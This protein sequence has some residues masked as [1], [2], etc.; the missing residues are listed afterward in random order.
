MPTTGWHI[1]KEED[2]LDH[3]HFSARAQVHLKLNEINPS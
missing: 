2:S 3:P 1:I